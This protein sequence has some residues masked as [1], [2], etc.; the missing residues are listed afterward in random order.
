MIYHVNSTFFFLGDPRWTDVLARP[1]RP[2]QRDWA[3]V[4]PRS[5]AR[6]ET[7]REIDNVGLPRYLSS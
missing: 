3:Q 6:G 7:D 4:L 2:P 1:A 5:L